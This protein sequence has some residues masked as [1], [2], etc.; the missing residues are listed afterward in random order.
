MLKFKEFCE[1]YYNDRIWQIVIADFG[2][3]LLTSYLTEA[4][5][6][7]YADAKL[8]QILTAFSKYGFVKMELTF[9]AEDNCIRVVTRT[10]TRVNE[11]KLPDEIKAAIALGRMYDS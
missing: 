9:G 1:Q 6:R 2:E 5:K 3:F 11:L 7:D 10:P 4:A 8:S